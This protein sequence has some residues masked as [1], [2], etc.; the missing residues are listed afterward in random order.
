[1]LDVYV[2]V[3]WFALF[4]ADMIGDVLSAQVVGSQEQKSDDDNSMNVGDCTSTQVVC[5]AISTSG[6]VCINSTA[7]V[8]IFGLLKTNWD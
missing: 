7:P 3:H 6:N 5:G 8:L 1:M 2:S 4:Y